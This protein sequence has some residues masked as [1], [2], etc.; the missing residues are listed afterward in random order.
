MLMELVIH[1]LILLIVLN[2]VTKLSLWRWWQ[3]ALYGLLLGGFAWWSLR[4][5][6][7]QSKTQLTDYLQ[8]T[9][10]LQTLAILIT[11]ESAIGLAFSLLWLN[12][13]SMKLLD[14]Y[15]SLLMF[16]VVF[17]LLTQVIFLTTGK[18]F[19]MVGLTFA[20]AIIVL[21]PLMAQSIRWLLPDKSSRVELHL[22]LTVLVCMLGLIST[23][24]GQMVYVVKEEPLDWVSLMTS[25]GFFIA[26]F[27]VGLTVHRLKWK[28]NR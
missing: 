22:Q 23:T 28:L 13:K 8:D 24:H 26:L 19:G 11:I 6:I 12:G 15:A 14:A 10:T 20:A 1:L 7:L 5:V 18:D 2:C 3:Q 17:Y 4:W 21:L 25:F 16:P 9:N 27:I